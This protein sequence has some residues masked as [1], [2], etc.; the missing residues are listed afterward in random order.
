MKKIVCLLLLLGG[1][2]AK[3]PKCISLNL[4]EISKE[5]G[6]PFANI[7]YPNKEGEDVIVNLNASMLFWIIQEGEKQ[8]EKSESQ[9]T[10]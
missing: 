10:Q 1:C 4:G 2:V 9:K 6:K 3:E 8:N 5:T 7:A